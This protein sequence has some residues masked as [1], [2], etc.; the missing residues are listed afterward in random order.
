[1]KKN[2][3]VLLLAPL[4]LTACAGN[5]THRWC[6]PQEMVVEKPP[7]V[8]E[9]ESIQLSADALFKFDKAGIND[10]LPKGKSELDALISKLNNHYINVKQIGVTGHTDRLGAE[11]YNL[12]LGMERAETIRNY[13]LSNGIQTDFNVSSKG[14]SEPLTTDCMNIMGQEAL[15]ACLQ[16]DRRVSL[17]IIGIKKS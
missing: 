11:R 17:D 8:Y 15:R 4:F 12:K 9:T 7:V 5:V 14:K 2:Y 6:S 13:L 3:I 10:L 1:M 16:P